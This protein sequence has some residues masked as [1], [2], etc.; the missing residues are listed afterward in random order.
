MVVLFLAESLGGSGPSGEELLQRN[1]SR[2]INRTQSFINT[3]RNFDVDGNYVFDS[4]RSYC[5]DK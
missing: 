4:T 3:N 2:Q 5:P 1:D